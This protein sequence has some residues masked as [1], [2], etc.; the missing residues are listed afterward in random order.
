MPDAD[1]AWLPPR[2]CLNDFDGN[3]GEYLDALYNR[4]CDDWIHHPPAAFRGKR[5]GLKRHPLFQGRE[6]TFWHFITEGAVEAERLH[7]LRRCECIG[8]PRAMLDAVG[9][10]RVRCWDQPGRGAGNDTRVAIALLD[11]SYL[12]VLS[13]RTDYVLPWTA[14]CVDQFHQRQ[15]LREEWKAVTGSNG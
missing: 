10:D 8:W 6:A 12:L 5:L 13:E 1:P 15:K 4:F 11:F 3:V 2:V 7:N 14:Y 9:T